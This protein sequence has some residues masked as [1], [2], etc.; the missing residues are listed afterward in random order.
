MG[1]SSAGLR[2]FLCQH[3]ASIPIDATTNDVC[4]MLIKPATGRSA[5]VECTFR[6]AWHQSD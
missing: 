6:A 4:N 3:D 1:I 5:D 2:H